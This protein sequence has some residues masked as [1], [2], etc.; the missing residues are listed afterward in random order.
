ME[1][2][3]LEVKRSSRSVAIVAVMVAL[4]LTSVVLIFSHISF[5][6]PFAS[7]YNVNAIF[8]DVKGSD[9]GHEPIYIAGVKIGVVSGERIIH[10]DEAELSLAIDSGNAPIY[11]DATIVQRPVTPLQDMYLEVTRGSPSAGRLPAGGTV[12]IGQTGT[13][14]DISR[15]LD[16]FTAP[17]SDRLHSLLL[18]LG[19]GLADHGQELQAAFV[20]LFPLLSTTAQVMRAVA[21]RQQ[22]LASLVHV[23]AD[24]GQALGARD[25]QIA[26]LVQSGDRTL[27]TIAA[28]D[29]PFSAMLSDLPGAV[30]A[31]QSSMH[32]LRVTADYLD[33]AVSSLRPVAERLQSGLSALQ[34]FA[35]QATP[36][37]L[38]ARTPL[39]ALDPLAISLRPTS[40]SLAGALSRLQ[41]QNPRL[42]F[43]TQRLEGC[44]GPV[45][46]FFQNTTSVFK[47]GDASGTFPRADESLNLTDLSGA[48]PDPEFHRLTDGC[49]QP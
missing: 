30:S 10:G 28:N 34:T 31:L 40:S 48:T 46:S 32:S 29:A 8:S 1:R 47:W 14:V 18:G 41:A 11:R 35:E 15:V 21:V 7:T 45:A 5:Q 13:P 17:T 38:A 36:A 39:R 20:Q 27:A 37:L 12:P 25:A 2:L 44:E 19:S 3:R 22:D 26:E 4:G 49:V 33:P 9:P 42:D 43:I 16:T 24:L 6:N 23:T